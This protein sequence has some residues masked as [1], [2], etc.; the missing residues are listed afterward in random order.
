ML[1]WVILPEEEF[2]KQADEISV[3]GSIV[4]CGACDMM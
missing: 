2:R 3:A 1:D 4:E